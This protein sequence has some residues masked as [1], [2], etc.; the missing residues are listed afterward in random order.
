M[1]CLIGFLQE[2]RFECTANTCSVWHVWQL[3]VWHAYK[4]YCC[5]LSQSRPYFIYVATWLNCSHLLNLA[6]LQ[7]NKLALAMP[8][9]IQ[10]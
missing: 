7:R 6:T 4:L 8:A 5:M 10:K 9:N 3:A 1:T 2:L